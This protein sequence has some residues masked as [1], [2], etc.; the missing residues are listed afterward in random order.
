MPCDSVLTKASKSRVIA[1]HKKFNIVCCRRF[2][3][4]H[5]GKGIHFAF[6]VTL[7]L[8]KVVFVKS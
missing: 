2:K 8:L 5:L 1:Y 6:N 7:C 3:Q 4:Y